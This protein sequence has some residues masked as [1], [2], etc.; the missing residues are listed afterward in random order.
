MTTKESEKR[1]NPV[2]N[3]RS[4]NTRRERVLTSTFFG[5]QEAGLWRC[6]GSGLAGH[7][8]GVLERLQDA[9][10][11]TGISSSIYYMP[12]PESLPRVSVRASPRL[13]GC[14]SPD[15]QVYKAT[16]LF[17]GREEEPLRRSKA[18]SRELPQRIDSLS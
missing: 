2:E 1:N 10:T 12:R 16:P 14:E 8:H 5:L 18:S 7:H 17:H 4:K 11:F 6:D 13:E 15:D 9:N 3:M